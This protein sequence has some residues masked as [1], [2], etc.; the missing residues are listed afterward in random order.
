M[1]DNS[2]M[3]TCYLQHLVTALVCGIQLI[4]III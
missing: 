4:M 3:V 1:D 2:G